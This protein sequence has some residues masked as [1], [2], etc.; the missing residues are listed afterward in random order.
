MLHLPSQ[1]AKVGRN[2]RLS[3]LAPPVAC[4]DAVVGQGYS[5]LRLMVTCGP[6]MVRQAGRCVMVERV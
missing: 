6:S 5:W 2:A 3:P 1:E 4:C